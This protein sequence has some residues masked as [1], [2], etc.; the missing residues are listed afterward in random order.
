MKSDTPKTDAMLELFRVCAANPK[1]KEGLEIF[2]QEIA[3]L[4]QQLSDRSSYIL[5]R[6]HNDYDQYGKYFVARFDRL[7]SIIDIQNA[8]A[9]DDCSIVD[10]ELAAHILTGGGR[11]KDENVWWYLTKYTTE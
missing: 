1:A 11:R 3:A 9:R 7:P 5:T 8:I 6:E 4:K 2:L 10:D